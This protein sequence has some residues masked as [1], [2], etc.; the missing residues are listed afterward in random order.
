MADKHPMYDFESAPSKLFTYLIDTVPAMFIKYTGASQSCLIK[1]ATTTTDLQ[2]VIGVL[3]SEAAD[4]NFTLPSGGT[5][6]TI[7]VSD[8]TADTMGEVIDFINSLDDYICIP[9]VTLRADATT[10]AFIVD[11]SGKQAKSADLDV[12]GGA[13]IYWDTTVHLYHGGVISN[14]S[15][16]P[17]T[18]PGGIG[19]EEVYDEVGA[20]NKLSHFTITPTYTGTPTCKLHEIA[21][22]VETEIASVPIGASTAATAFPFKDTYG[23]VYTAKAGSRILMRFGGGSALTATASPIIYGSSVQMIA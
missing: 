21:G 11:T 6:G 18:G 9:W 12:T 8:A 5:D 22:K 19:D 4:A 2:S 17:G 20:I 10:A 1:T 7:D 14:M 23:Q 15:F 13:V 3:G 16:K